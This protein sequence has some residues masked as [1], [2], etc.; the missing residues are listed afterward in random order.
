MARVMP[1]RRCSGSTS[2]TMACRWI[3][4]IRPSSVSCLRTCW[5]LRDIKGADRGS[6][7]QLKQRVQNA[8]DATTA[9]F[10]GGK[11]TWK[12][13]K[14]RVAPDIERLSSEHPEIVQQY[15]KPVAGS[16]RFV[17]QTDRRSAS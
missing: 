17:I 3:S 7:S 1:V 8:G 11:V 10:T 6:E 9:L 14:D 12:K 5:K 13:S 2:K 16:R 15:S 4:P